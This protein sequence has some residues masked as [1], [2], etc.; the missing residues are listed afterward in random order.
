MPLFPPPKQVLAPGQG[1]LAEA[2]F[3]L[4]L[5][6]I[7]VEDRSCC[8]QFKQHALEK[9]IYFE[10][11]VPVG[12]SSNLLH[13]LLGPFLV[14]EGKLT[15]VQYQEALAASARN[16]VKLGEHLAAKEL[17][18][19]YDLFRMMQKNLALK[20]L[21]C[22]T[23]SAGSWRILP[24]AGE[25][26][27]PLKMNPAQLVLTG[28]SSSAPFEMIA[29]GLVFFDEQ[30]FALV[31]VPPHEL[32]A[33]KLSAK[34]SRLLR[35]LGERPTFPELT[36]GSQLPTEEA[37]RRLYA[38]M[39]LGFVGL[40]EEV[41]ALA[42]SAPAPEVVKAPAASTQ[43]SPEVVRNEVMELFLKHRSLDSFDLLGIGESPTFA[44]LKRAYL[45]FCERF[46]PWPLSGEEYGGIAEKAETLFLAGARA[47]AEVAD[48]ERRTQAVMRRRNAEE[49]KQRKRT[50][51]FRIQT[52]LLDAR[53]QFDEGRRFLQETNTKAAIQHFEYAV[54]IE[55]RKALF[56]AWLGWAR[57]LS[58]PE[59]AHQTALKD[60]EAAAK[61]DPACSEAFWFEGEI[62][63]SRGDLAGADV[64]LRRAVKLEPGRP[65]Y[66]ES[67]RQL[68]LLQKKQ[69]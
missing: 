32:K 31:P 2:P 60:L 61:A 48:P 38:L 12:C 59:Y 46:A 9:K 20:I 65:E 52:D 1:T 11:G 23:W 27:T 63:K 64:A 43:R 6:A 67:L 29:S 47:Y 24:D 54:E 10:E 35:V 69:R 30:R 56:K 13:E 57:Y 17:V 55:P 41:D 49:A 21:D 15:E 8:L 28:C 14:D 34:D 4:L 39:L 16:G 22:F 18:S 25:A 53:S 19:P 37:M 58:S 26:E 68:G 42:A 66:A 44:E 50:T 51:D 40:A 62:R 45:G 33:L 3:P 7:F 5:H 36:A